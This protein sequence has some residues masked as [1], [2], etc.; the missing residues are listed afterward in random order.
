MPKISELLAKL[1]K[2]DPET[3]NA[4]ETE[5]SMCHLPHHVMMQLRDASQ[6]LAQGDEWKNRD[7]VNAAISAQE[8]LKQ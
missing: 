5:M 2:V 7:A 8:R 4:L 3:T 1:R 6:S